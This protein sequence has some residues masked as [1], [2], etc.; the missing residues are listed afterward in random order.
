MHTGQLRRRLT[1]TSDESLAVALDWDFFNHFDPLSF[2]SCPRCC[3][4]IRRRR[5]CRS[6]ARGPHAYAVLGAESLPERGN[7]SFGP[8]RRKREESRRQTRVGCER[9]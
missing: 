2:C 9:E 6:L 3:T 7:E 4:S 5:R 8:L 1:L